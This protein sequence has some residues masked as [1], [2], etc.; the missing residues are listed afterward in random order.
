MTT[1]TTTTTA[2]TAMAKAIDKVFT[3]PEQSEGVGARVRRAIGTP[4]LRNFNPFIMFDH[5]KVPSTAGFPDHPHRG[6]ETITYVIDGAVDHEDFTGSKGTLNAGDLQF[7]TAGKGIVHA[8][9]PAAGPNGEVQVVEGIQLWVDLPDHLKNCEPRYRDLK[10]AEIPTAQSDKK[11]LTVKVISGQAMGV[12]SVKDL[13]YTPVWYLDYFTESNY[14]GTEMSQTMPAG[15]NSLLYVMKGSAIVDGKVINAHDVATLSTK[16][17]TIDFTP[18]PN[19]R[20]IIIGAQILNQKTVQHGPFV[21]SS[22]EGIMNAFMDYQFSSNGFER[23]A[24][25]ESEIGK[26]MM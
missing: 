7:M 18:A 1:T 5:F 26:R 17:E 2:T 20:I 12:D 16:G 23:A 15:F 3:A 19:S 13:A 22:E 10:A 25:W 9:M 8:E 6:Q 14:D 24:T 4:K 11:D 21:A